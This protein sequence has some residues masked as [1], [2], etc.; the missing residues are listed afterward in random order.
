[1][2]KNRKHKKVTIGQNLRMIELWDKV[3]D[4]ISEI[5]KEEAPD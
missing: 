1:V 5:E 2:K 4:L 3:K